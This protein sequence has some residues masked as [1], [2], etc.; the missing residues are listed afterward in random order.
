M[1]ARNIVLMGPM[2]SGKT[3][4]GRLLAARLD[5]FFVDTDEE[6]ARRASEPVAEIFRRQGESAFRDLESAVVREVAARRD[7]VVATG[8]GVVLRE[9]NVRLLRESGTTFLLWAQAAELWERLRPER[10]SRPL[11]AGSHPLERLDG[12][13]SEREGRYRA[14]ADVVISTGGRTAGE[15]AGLIMDSLEGR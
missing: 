4:V 3:T 2:G 15:V 11:L 7:Q 13:L 1:S 5:R 8:G 12:L 9:E 14:A 6:V 10:G